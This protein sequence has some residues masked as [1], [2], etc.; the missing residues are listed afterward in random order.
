MDEFSKR[1]NRLIKIITIVGMVVFLVIV[2]LIIFSFISPENTDNIIS[3]MPKKYI[4]IG[5]LILVILLVI[6]GVIINKK[7]RQKLMTTKPKFICEYLDTFYYTLVSNDDCADSLIMYHVVKDLS[8]SRIYAVPDE[9]LNNIKW[10]KTKKN[11]NMTISKKRIVE[12]TKVYFWIDEE[13]KNWYERDGNNLAIGEQ[14]LIYSSEP[15]DCIY[16]YHE[17][18]KLYNVNKKYD[19]SLLDKAIFAY[20]YAKFVDE[21]IEQ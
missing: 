7:Y 18:P 2:G 12:G 20:G 11:F 15:D 10:V 5:V 8:T 21:E 16:S 6:Y 4:V 19:I 3:N 14:K 13:M 9:T 1:N 17:T